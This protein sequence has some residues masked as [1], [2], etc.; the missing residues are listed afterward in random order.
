V[1]IRQRDMKHPAVEARAAKA[2][3]HAGGKRGLDGADGGA[4]RL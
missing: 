3:V 4:V 2:P 1:F